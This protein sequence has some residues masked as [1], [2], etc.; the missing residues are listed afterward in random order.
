[1]RCGCHPP[2]WDDSRLRGH[3]SLQGAL[4]AELQ[5]KREKGSMIAGISVD[6]MR[7]GPEGIEIISRLDV[8]EVAKDF[9]GRARTTLIPRPHDG[10]MPTV[11][12]AR[13]WPRTLTVFRNALTE[14]I[15]ASGIEHKIPDGPKVKAALLGDTREAFYR[16]CILDHEPGITAEQR[17]DSKRKAL[18][19]AIEKAQAL[20]LIGATSFPDG[21]QL[22]WLTV[23]L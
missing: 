13:K 4:V 11:G 9:R 19:R 8:V 16:T 2:G 7:E 10:D 18:Q 22:L 17:Q 1:M 15:L 3:S 12:E 5:V 21:R 23:D 6:H 20:N 14:A